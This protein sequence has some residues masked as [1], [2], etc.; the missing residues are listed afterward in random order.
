MLPTLY[1][2][3]ALK[4]RP[5]P[6]RVWQWVC[7]RLL[8]LMIWV[9][10]GLFLPIT[11]VVAQT[12]IPLKIIV[13]ERNNIAQ[14][15]FDAKVPLQYD[16]QI[17][18]NTLLIY[19][20]QPIIA[21]MTGVLSK[22]PSYFA[23]GSINATGTEATV[24]MK[25]AA[26]IKSFRLNNRIIFEFS[27]NKSGEETALNKSGNANLVTGNTAA[28]EKKPAESTRT[29]QKEDTSPKSSEKPAPA[30]LATPSPPVATAPATTPQTAP[31][32]PSSPASPTAPKISDQAPL[33]PGT[34]TEAKPTQE[35]AKPATNAPTPQD[36]KSGS[37]VTD[38][39]QT[40]K[41]RAGI[42][43]L[44]VPKEKKDTRDA[45]EKQPEEI[46]NDTNIVVI[47]KAP[48]KEVAPVEKPA[49]KPMEPD[50]NLV[51]INKKPT[52][53]EDVEQ[54]NNNDKKQIQ[55]QQPARPRKLSG[56]LL[57][58]F[59]DHGNFGRI[60][61]DGMNNVEAE[62]NAARGNL[63]ITLERPSDI[64]SN[65]FMG[66]LEKRISEP[67]VST[68]DTETNILLHIPVTDQVSSFR[69][70]DKLI[71]D[72]AN[73]GILPQQ[74]LNDPTGKSKDAANAAQVITAEAVTSGQV[75]ILSIDQQKAE[76]VLVREGVI[77]PEQLA[78]SQK[79]GPSLVQFRFD[80]KGPV[81]AAIFR[82]GEYIWFV[83]DQANSLDFDPVGGDRQKIIAKLEQVPIK[84]FTVLRLLVP[85]MNINPALT[86][87]KNTWIID[88]RLGPILPARNLP[89]EI[90][91]NADRGAHVFFPQ[92]KAGQELM[93]ED[94]AVGDRI[95]VLTYIESGVGVKNQRHY[96]QFDLLP[97]AQGLAVESRVDNIAFSYD[98]GGYYMNTQNG[99]F[100][101]GYSPDQ[102][103]LAGG[104]AVK[105]Y[106]L[107]NFRD[108]AKGPPDD[109]ILNR[110]KIMRANA[111]LPDDKT[112]Q[113]EIDL[114][115]FYL[116]NNYPQEALV[117]MD[118]INERDSNV[119]NTEAMLG[120][121]G[122][123]YILTDRLDEALAIFSNRNY[124]R[125]SE[126]SLWL[127]ALL[128][129]QGRQREAYSYLRNS[130]SILR[131]YPPYL[132]G[133]LGNIIL[134]TALE[135]KDT[136]YADI[137]GKL[138]QEVRDQ[139][140][141]Y[142]AADFDYNI[143]RLY[144][145]HTQFDLA[146]DV[147]TR[148]LT[149]GDLKNAVRSQ[150]ALINIGLR[151]KTMT[152]D[153][154]IEKLETLRYQWRGDQFE[155]SVLEELGKLYIANK[156]YINGLDTYNAAVTYFPNDPLIEV[157]IGRMKGSFRSLFLDGEADHIPPARALAIYDSYKHLSPEGEEG[158]L[159]VSRLIDRLIKEDLLE[160]AANFLESQIDHSLQ[161][162]EL[163]KAGTKLALVRLMGEQPEKALGAIDRTDYG[164][165]GD[166]ELDYRRRLKASAYFMMKNN[167]EAIK[168]LA[169]DVTPEADILRRD[170][171]WQAK[172]WT[173]VGKNLQRLIGVISDKDS[174]TTR[175]DKG[176]YLVQWAVAVRQDNDVRGMEYLRNSY[177]N[178]IA[179]TSS[180]PIFNYLT[181]NQS[182]AVSATE[183]ADYEA[184]IAKISNGT[185]LQEF[186]GTVNKDNSDQFGKQ[187]SN[188]DQKS[189]QTARN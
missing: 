30:S 47:K 160:R 22:A 14:M 77:N 3:L 55:T 2:R 140:P 143:A 161:G 79:I 78:A 21:E 44:L 81:G 113:G 42:F 1:P 68:S 131:S 156:Q 85:D 139:L 94:P 33:L 181:E 39:P 185:S 182:Q 20:S 133:E 124:E 164:Y 119:A 174:L 173:E 121:R 72:I 28:K 103:I 99:L 31:T 176:K 109:Y 151:Q 16:A 172:N 93:L 52:V 155:L 107:F 74:Q 168:L 43:G 32:Q 84:G 130:S 149:F 129:K 100:L 41:I 98:K 83:F 62:I 126:T 54:F 180:A 110:Q 159:V 4:T 87:E 167:D 18:G 89:I 147:W 92:T 162:Q 67:L 170:I 115:R 6:S 105:N 114:A 9:G 49:E 66:S 171:N 8:A 154:A 145:T 56:S 51:L 34:Q 157:I 40:P 132:K 37:L 45:T 82:R 64:I 75:K 152:I 65:Q 183:I 112:I 127:G 58:N 26:T 186:L 111:D 29:A 70:G 117:Q 10:F 150:L 88:L 142:A 179:N 144:A 95:Y 50:N 69:I 163:I 153:E 125:F 148:L 138:V 123:A 73:Q 35:A 184:Q 134:Q 106:V 120:L 48:P 24:S 101:S 158:N 13:W 122:A 188:L 17:A 19:F 80:W 96:P 116:A 146:N 60:I 76:N 178:Y 128:A 136:R 177:G 5:I 61:F 11:H 97:T 71:V 91:V 23:G 38:L 57:V 90:T 108:W 104:G 165:I 25:T 118:L 7:Y 12:A 27:A 169:G 187:T 135:A 189:Q 137:I 36:E 46:T 15:T 59:E 175:E 166:E 102:A 53:Q 141:R 63:S 86:M